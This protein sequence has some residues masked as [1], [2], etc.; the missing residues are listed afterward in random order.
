MAHRTKAA[1]R[2]A[3][4]IKTRVPVSSIFS[5]QS[6]NQPSFCWNYSKVNT[7]SP[8][9]QG[10]V[11][12][13]IQNLYLLP[14]KEK[15]LINSA[16]ESLSLT[17]CPSAEQLLALPFPNNIE[18]GLCT[19]CGISHLFQKSRYSLACLFEL[20]GRRLQT[21][22]LVRLERPLLAGPSSR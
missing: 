10:S 13:H 18:R 6:V 21:S 14:L 22:Q 2:R 4:T 1:N 11:R 12:P 15:P 17:E 9:L 20:A 8:R 7:R 5:K 16:S 19:T 3:Y